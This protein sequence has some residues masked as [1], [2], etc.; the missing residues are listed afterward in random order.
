VYRLDFDGAITQSAGAHPADTAPQHQKTVQ[1][2]L[3]TM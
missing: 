2:R 3:K 1:I